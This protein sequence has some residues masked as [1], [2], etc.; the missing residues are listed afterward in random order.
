MTQQF[1]TECLR[2]KNEHMENEM[3]K[4]YNKLR[5]QYVIFC[6]DFNELSLEERENRRW[7][8]QCKVNYDKIIKEVVASVENEMESI[9]SSKYLTWE[10]VELLIAHEKTKKVACFR[11]FKK[12]LLLAKESVTPV[13]ITVEPERDTLSEIEYDELKE[14]LEMGQFVK[15]IPHEYGRRKMHFSLS[16]SKASPKV[17]KSNKA[18]AYVPSIDLEELDD[19]EGKEFNDQLEL[20][21]LLE[22][23]CIPVIENFF[24]AV[25]CRLILDG[26]IDLGLKRAVYFHCKELKH[27]GGF[28]FS[29]IYDEPEVVCK[30]VGQRL[31]FF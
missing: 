22:P 7:Q 23:I 13:S 16:S 29:N 31:H 26:G 11:S 10:D 4:L 30:E 3:Q 9:L 28:D 25:I 24:T 14:R 15:T 5:E 27:Y 6:A 20:F 2:T 1:K 12:L 21:Q 18:S 19:L 8:L 17:R